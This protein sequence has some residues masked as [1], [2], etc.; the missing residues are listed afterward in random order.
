MLSQHMAQNFETLL[1]EGLLWHLP[2]KAWQQ[3]LMQDCLAVS[4]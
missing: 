3:I 4:S 1:E 2:C